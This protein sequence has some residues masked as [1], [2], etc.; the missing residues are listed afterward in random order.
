MGRTRVGPPPKAAAGCPRSLP[1]AVVAARGRRCSRSSLSA[2]SVAC[3]RC[4][5][6]SLPPAFAAAR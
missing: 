6:R 4:C 1:P 2:V 5:P 3:G